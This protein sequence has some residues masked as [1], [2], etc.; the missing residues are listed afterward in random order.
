MGLQY[1][2]AKLELQFN[3]NHTYGLLVPR[4]NAANYA[5]L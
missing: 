3:Y 1:F 4:H 2:D 5:S